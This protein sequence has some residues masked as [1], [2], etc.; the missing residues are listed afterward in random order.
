MDDLA[1]RKY[2]APIPDADWV[3]SADDV[4]QAQLSVSLSKHVPGW[5]GATDEQLFEVA[6]DI[7]NALDDT[8]RAKV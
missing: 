3:V 6:Q 4:V 1:E 5:P 8:P 2:K 7:I